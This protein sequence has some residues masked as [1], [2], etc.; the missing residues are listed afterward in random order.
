MNWRY[1][2]FI[3]IFTMIGVFL[4]ILILAMMSFLVEWYWGCLI[5]GSVGIVLAVA[6]LLLIFDK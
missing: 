3:Q 6:K 1:R 2:K 4:A 5:F